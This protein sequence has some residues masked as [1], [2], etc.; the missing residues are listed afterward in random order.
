MVLIKA[1]IQTNFEFFS[2]NQAG[3]K[4]FCGSGIN[5]NEKIQIQIDHILYT[6]MQREI[7]R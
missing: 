3:L 5:Q 4:S 7:P 6:T 2:K 1:R